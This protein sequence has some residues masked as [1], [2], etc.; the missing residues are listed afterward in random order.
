MVSVEFL[1]KEQFPSLAP[2]I[3]AILDGNMRP[4]LPKRLSYEEEYRSWYGAVAEGI[5]KPLRQIILV[6]RED[7]Q[8]LGFVQYYANTQTLMLEEVQILPNYQ[9]T[10]NF[11]P[12]LARFLMDHLEAAPRFA[13]AFVHPANG[14]SAALQEKLGMVCT[15][16]D[17]SGE[18][19]HYRGEYSRFSARFL[20]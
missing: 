10:V 9:H 2:D 7:R 14:P 8:L 6:Y 13:E 18:Y 17:G 5:Q 15:G 12:R 19:L 20:R 4:I 1:N 16:T 11:L 3:F